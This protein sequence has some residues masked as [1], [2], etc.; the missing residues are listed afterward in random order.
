MVYLGI[1]I[2][3]LLFLATQIAATVLCTP[4]R[5]QDWSSPSV[6]ARC[7][8]DVPFAVV[9]GSINVLID[10]YILYLPIPILWKLQL[11]SR[12]KIGVIVIFTTS[13]V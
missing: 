2:S 4:R 11:R 9:R 3:T 10:F 5:G 7:M 1:A 6:V 13:L 12:K 8:K